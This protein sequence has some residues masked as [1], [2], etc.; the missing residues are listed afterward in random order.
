[1]AQAEYPKDY[2]QSVLHIP[3]GISN[4]ENG[5]PVCCSLAMLSHAA[6][7]VVRFPGAG[8]L[9]YTNT[10]CSG[11][12]RLAYHRFKNNKLK[13]VPLRLWKLVI[14]K[15]F[16]TSST[17]TSIVASRC[18]NKGEWGFQFSTWVRATRREPSR[19][20]R[21]I[22]VV[23]VSVV[24]PEEHIRSTTFSFHPPVNLVGTETSG[25]APKI[26]STSTRWK[27]QDLRKFCCWLSL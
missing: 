6:A 7:S 19:L 20:S 2:A 10:A 1:M 14:V 18:N 17:S 15:A 24:A 25:P 12:F 23:T 26:C 21:P 9:K 27:P 4:F 13:P 16:I 22:L 11:S 3:T 5:K 8:G